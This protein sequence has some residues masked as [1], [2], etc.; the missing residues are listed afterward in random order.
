L[1]TNLNGAVAESD[2]TQF[3]GYYTVD[4]TINRN[5]A[6]M[7]SINGYTGQVWLHTWH[8]TFIQE[9]KLN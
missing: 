8:G 2:A 4:F 7:L 3:Y 9:T 6:G 5:T 1:D